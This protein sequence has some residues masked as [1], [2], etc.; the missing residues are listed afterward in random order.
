MEVGEEVHQ[1]DLRSESR[2]VRAI[3]PR[4]AERSG[5]QKGQLIFNAHLSKEQL[6]HGP[7]QKARPMA[8][9]AMP[10]ATGP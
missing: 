8:A 10:K 2:S 4:R 7:S 3:A 5:V 9:D 6:E 1:E